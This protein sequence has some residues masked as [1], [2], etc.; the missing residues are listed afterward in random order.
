MGEININ[1]YKVD[2]FEHHVPESID[3]AFKDVV[4]NAGKSSTHIDH[5]LVLS[6]EHEENCRK[7][8]IDNKIFHLST[9]VLN[10]AI[11]EVD[12]QV[13]KVNRTEKTSSEYSSEQEFIV[14]CPLDW[15]DNLTR[16]L[17]ELNFE[18]KEIKEY[19]LIIQEYKEQC[20]NPSNGDSYVP[21]D[22]NFDEDDLSFLF[23]KEVIKRKN[24][25][26][27]LTMTTAT[28]TATNFTQDQQHSSV[29]NEQPNLMAYVSSCT[30]A[31]L[32]E[33]ILTF[34][35]EE[36]LKSYQYAHSTKKKQDAMYKAINKNPANSMEQYNAVKD[37]HDYVQLSA[38][39]VKEAQDT[40]NSYKTGLR[41][42][43]N[44]IEKNFKIKPETRKVQ[45]EILGQQKCTK[46]IENGL[47]GYGKAVVAGTVIGKQDEVVAA[48]NYIAVEV[49]KIA[50]AQNV[51]DKTLK[52][53]E[54]VIKNVNSGINNLV[55]SLHT[56]EGELNALASK[57]AVETKQQRDNVTN[58]VNEV[59]KQ[60]AGK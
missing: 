60:K 13:Y 41:S 3:Q 11:E 16:Q 35:D 9:E 21:I 57:L 27:E 45:Q 14:H 17:E 42:R 58:K 19:S 49:S 26:E 55:A 24:N 54:T 33:L 15:M 22:A 7:P 51:D 2:D 28:A 39:S 56:E 53:V 52:G 37:F 29:K 44:N 8:V 50:N 12:I 46:L 47:K 25:K 30:R 23:S 40:M 36:V 31:F 59:V 4:K 32:D 10:E 38:E 5:Y 34:N 43:V 20:N 6:E 48:A 1:K 18:V